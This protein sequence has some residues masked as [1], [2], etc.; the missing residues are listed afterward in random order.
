M[1]YGGLFYRPDRLQTQRAS[2]L[3]VG[4]VFSPA[5]LQKVTSVFPFDSGAM[6]GRSELAKWRAKMDPFTDRFQLHSTDAAGDTG[7]LIKILCTA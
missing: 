4:L 2:D 7:S 3:P 5:A 1:S 6:A